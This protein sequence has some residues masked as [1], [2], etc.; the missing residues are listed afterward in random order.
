MAYQRPEA[1][2]QEEVAKIVN[3]LE[4]MLGK[5]EKINDLA[6]FIITERRLEKSLVDI[7]Q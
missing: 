6:E 7:S 5:S 2:I 4:K 3:D 1:T